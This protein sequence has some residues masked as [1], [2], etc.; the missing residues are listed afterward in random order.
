MNRPPVL[1]S[2]EPTNARQGRPVHSQ[3]P[4]LT[5]TVG[6][7]GCRIRG[8]HTAYRPYKRNTYRVGNEVPDEM[9]V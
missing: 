1:R 4:R 2:K 7:R 9:D 5:F 8:Y 3:V 6:A